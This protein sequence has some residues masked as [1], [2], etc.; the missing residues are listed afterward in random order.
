MTPCIAAGLSLCTVVAGDQ[1]RDGGDDLDNFF[2]VKS[3]RMVIYATW[4][5]TKNELILLG[6]PEK[7]HDNV[8]Y[9]TAHQI[10]FA[11]CKV[12]PCLAA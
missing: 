8:C 7:P 12:Y 3:V 11:D 4:S 10:A 6:Q 5:L 9:L 1:Y 2:K